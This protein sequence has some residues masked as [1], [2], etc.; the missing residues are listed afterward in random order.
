MVG[1][2]LGSYLP[3]CIGRK[4][5]KRKAWLFLAMVLG[6]LI[7]LGFSLA[8]DEDLLLNMKHVLIL[9][10]SL[11]AGGFSGF[12]FSFAAVGYKYRFDDEKPGI[13]YLSD[14]IGSSLAGI[15]VSVLFIPLMGIGSVVILLIILLIVYMIFHGLVLN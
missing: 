6:L 15:S 9:V 2:S 3:Y 14:L 4:T 7:I 5:V 1:L 13:F 8:A 11:L 12:L 10:S